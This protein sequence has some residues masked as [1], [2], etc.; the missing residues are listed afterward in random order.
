[1]IYLYYLQS[2]TLGNAR[3]CDR[4]NFIQHNSNK[5]L[6]INATENNIYLDCSRYNIGCDTFICE[7]NEIYRQNS[8]I[9]FVQMIFDRSKIPGKYQVQL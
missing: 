7:F 6:S 9:V 3:K 4:L 5:L 1:M 2:H 8:E